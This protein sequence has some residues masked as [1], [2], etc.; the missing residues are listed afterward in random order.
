MVDMS[1]QLNLE[2][3]PAAAAAK[4]S[5][6]HHRHS[7]MWKTLRVIPLPG[8]MLAIYNLLLVGGG[9]MEV[10]MSAR[11]FALNLPSGASWA[12]SLGHLLVAIAV[13]T[14]Y[15]EMLKATRTSTGSVP[16]HVLSLLVAGVYLI[17]FIVVPGCGTSTF[18]VLGL[19]SFLDVVAGFTISIVAAR[20]DLA[21][22]GGD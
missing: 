17:E 14:L 12:M 2:K 5:G 18:L 20:R 15:F 4:R 7:W 19:I 21:F 11:A 3:V 10:R 13:I 16:D 8:V 9:D 1:D 22:Q 6:T